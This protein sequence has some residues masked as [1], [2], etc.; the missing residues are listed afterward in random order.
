MLDASL[1]PTPPTPDFSSP[2]SRSSAHGHHATR[3]DLRGRALLTAEQSHA[4]LAHVQVR[5]AQSILASACRSVDRDT[6][7]DVSQ[8]V[9]VNIWRQLSTLESST[10]VAKYG[11]DFSQLVPTAWVAARNEI[12]AA[13]RPRSVVRRLSVSMSAPSGADSELTLG[14]VVRSD[15]ETPDSDA[16]LDLIDVQRAVR[17]DVRAAERSSRG[18]A[19]AERRLRQMLYRFLIHDCGYT[20][21]EIAN[22]QLLTSELRDECLLSRIEEVLGE[23]MVRWIR[24]RLGALK[25]HRHLSQVGSGSRKGLELLCAATLRTAPAPIARPR[26]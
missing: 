15:G 2:D 13:L 17:A 23:A 3:L 16:R 20:I 6:A 12:R 22:P 14:D 9:F 21:E 18:A 24:L 4:I 1:P 7:E 8:Q 26:R 25:P 10:L 5:L 11:P 19:A